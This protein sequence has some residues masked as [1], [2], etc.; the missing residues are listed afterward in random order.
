MTEFSPGNNLVQL[1]REWRRKSVKSGKDGAVLWLAKMLQG[2]V[3][4]PRISRNPWAADLMKKLKRLWR[5][6]QPKFN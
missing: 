2:F 6:A 4:N 5:H 1:H 3:H